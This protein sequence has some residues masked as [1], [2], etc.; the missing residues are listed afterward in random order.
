MPAF[1][2][3]EPITLTFDMGVGDVRITAEDRTDTVV[4]IGPTDEKD[5]SDVKAAERTTVEF[6]GGVLSIRTPKAKPMDF[7]RKSRSVDVSVAL[8]AGSHVRGEVQVADLRCA[9]RIGECTF[10]AATGNIEVDHS[11]PVHLRMSAGHV[12]VRRVDGDADVSTST[13]RIR[14]GDVDGA[15]ETRN[16]NGSTDIGAVLGDVRVRASNGDVAIGRALGDR[17]D[18]EIS[19]GGIRVGEV[20]RGSVALKTASGDVEVGIGA[21][22]SARLDLSTGFGRVTN[23][24]EEAAEPS[25]KAVDVRAKTSF[26]DITVRRS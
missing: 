7:S 16:L 5:S 4:E 13:G 22:L 23:M 20:A 17:T 18:V 3:P 10:K 25:E 2:T 21:G 19:N 24:L 11:G 12:T 1:D 15:V 9:G 26:G 6:S 8:P 14:I